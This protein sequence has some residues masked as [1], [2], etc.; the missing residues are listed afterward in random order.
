MRRTK[1]G[2]GL[3]ALGVGRLV[4]ISNEHTPAHAHS[5]SPEGSMIQSIESETKGP[6]FGSGRGWGKTCLA[7]GTGLTWFVCEACVYCDRIPMA[8][9]FMSGSFYQTVN[10]GNLLGEQFTKGA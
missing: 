9:S 7:A 4:S 8:A 2:G 5:S 1:E 3:I 10:R 6:Y